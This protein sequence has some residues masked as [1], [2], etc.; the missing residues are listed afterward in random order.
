MDL[1][2]IGM[3]SFDND[4]K[5]N[6]F[7][8]NIYAT[9]QLDYER[10]GWL[11]S[12]K[13]PVKWFHHNVNGQND[14]I[15]FL[16]RFSVRK[17]MS[18]KSE[19]STFVAYQLNSPSVYMHITA[20]VLSDYRNLF[21]ANDID[22]YSQ[23]V[24]VSVSYKYRNPLTSFFTNVS[25][26]YNYSRSSIMSGQ[27]FIDDFIVSTV[28]DKL[29]ES[30][31][32]YLAGGVSKGLGHSR[33]VIGCDINAS[34]NSASSMRDN[35]IEDYNQQTI[36][37]KP[38]FKGSLS[39]W[40]SANYEAK[41]EF[42]RLK[43]GDISNNTLS[44]NQKLYASVIPNDRWQFTF[45]TEHFLTRFP[46]GNIQNLILLDASAVWQLSNKIRLSLTANNLLNKR[47][48]Q[49]V[50]YGTLSRSEH[51]YQIRARN[52]LASIQYRF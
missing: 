17:K 33:M 30:N 46:G 14:Y 29:S 15:N 11:L 13:F 12:A 38:F 28:A 22:K 47:H 45:G 7:L 41:Y 6:S 26:S 35:V 9:P 8:S 10:N 1:S 2:L 49:Y 20:P 44:F 24:V 16:P 19:V 3:G 40:L 50:T 39:K 32:W 4:E 5:Y 31:S 18:A 42:Y 27:L 36:S 25:V 51:S 34:T 43:F 37:V 48:Y 23:N 52:I 21:V